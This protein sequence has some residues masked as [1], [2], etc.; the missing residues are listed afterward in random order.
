MLS[1]RINA[2][3]ARSGQFISVCLKMHAELILSH[4]YKKR[5]ILL[6]VTN[7]LNCFKNVKSSL[8]CLTRIQNFTLPLSPD[9]TSRL[10]ASYFTAAWSAHPVDR[11][12]SSLVHPGRAIWEAVRPRSRNKRQRTDGQLFALYSGRCS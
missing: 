6:L 8:F 3:G 11:R 10:T 12:G 9:L 2:V 4:S 1:Q 7:I 5:D